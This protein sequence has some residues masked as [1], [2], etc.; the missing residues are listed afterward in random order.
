MNKWAELRAEADQTHCLAKRETWLKSDFCIA[1]FCPPGFQAYRCHRPG[2]RL[3]GGAL[4]FVADLF[5]QTA[6]DTLC[7]ENIQ[8]AE[9]VI[10]LSGVA[11]H[12]PWWSSRIKKALVRKQAAGQRLC[13]MG[14]YLRH[15]QY[16]RERKSFDC[17]LLDAKRAFELSL[18]KKAKRY[19]K[20][21]DGEHPAA[22]LVR[23]FNL[24]M[25]TATLPQDWKVANVAPIHKGDDRELA[26]SAQHPNAV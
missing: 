23:L 10:K 20:A 1:G 26:V 17:I 11:D 15:L 9:C 22:P 4:L 12:P 16:L 14:G 24:C 7:T 2:D 25:T 8:A 18:A 5:P 21:F 6:V 13:A 19:H 3:G